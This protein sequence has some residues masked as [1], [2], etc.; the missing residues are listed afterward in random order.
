MIML[1]M[2]DD[3]VVFRPGRSGVHTAGGAEMR[4]GADG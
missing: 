1:S 3:S 4:Q 2:P